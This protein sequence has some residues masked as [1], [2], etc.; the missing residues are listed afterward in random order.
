MDRDFFV[1]KV[2]TLCLEKGL[3]PT[4]ACKESG[5]GGSF[6]SDINRGQVPSVAK[7]QMLADYLGVTTSELLGETA[8]PV[9]PAGKSALMAAFWGGETDLTPEELDSM[10][11][12][13]ERFAAFLAEKKRKEKLHD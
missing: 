10:W 5:V 1:Q 4:N 6:L 12:D 3:K 9:E 8:S 11:D 13:V 2:K 7:V